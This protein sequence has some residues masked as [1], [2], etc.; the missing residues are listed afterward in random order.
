MK[1]PIKHPIVTTALL[2]GLL[3]TACSS[4]VVPRDIP[5]PAPPEPTPT[6]RELVLPPDDRS[7]SAPIEWWYYNGH[8][9]SEAGQEYSFHYVIFQTEDSDAES[10]TEFGQAGITDI[11][12]GKHMYIGSERLGSSR[13]LTEDGDNSLLNLQLGNFDLEIA[14]DGSHTFSAHD[15]NG[16]SGLELVTETPTEAMLHDGIGWMDWPFG[17]TYYYSYP[18]MQAHGVLTVDG[19]SINVKG[20]VW[21]DHQWGDF[22]V[23]GKPAGWQWFAIHLDDHRSLMIA[24]VRGAEGEVLAIDGTLIQSGSEQHVLDVEQDGIE[25][26]V[27]E[28]WTSPRTAGEYPAKWRLR[29]DSINLDIVMTPAIADQEI[30]ALPYGNQAAA[31]WEGRVDVTDSSSGESLGRGFAELSGYVEPEPLSWRGEKR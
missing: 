25:L 17:W 20:E 23:V 2:I 10:Q 16:T 1:G 13:S 28:H 18:R 6:P 29:I 27:Q 19:R 30:P 9:K 12:K 4:G 15:P 21:F 8:L 31:Y 14:A 24:E 26:E 11:Q 3:H 7:H 22:F 5:T